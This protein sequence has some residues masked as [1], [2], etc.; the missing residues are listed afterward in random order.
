MRSIVEGCGVGRLTARL[1]CAVAVALLVGGLATEPSAFAVWEGV[2]TFGGS[3]MPVLEEMFSEETQLGGAGGMAVNVNGTGGVAPGTVYVAAEPGK[4]ARVARYSPVAGGGLSFGE[5]WQVTMVEGAYERCGPEG[6]PAYPSCA[7]VAHGRAGTVGIAVD[8]ATGNVYVEHVGSAEGEG[9]GD[10][11]VEFSPDGSKVIARF[12]K[13]AVEH[14][15][16]FETV[17]ESPEKIHEVHGDSLAVDDAGEVYV[18]D[19]TSLREERSRLMVFKPASPGDYAHYLYAGEVASFSGP[20]TPP[21]QPVIDAAGHI[22]TDD[23]DV[24]EERGVEVPSAYPA[25]SSPPLCSFDFTKG[26]ITAMT[27]DPANGEVFFFSSKSPKRVRRLGPCDRSTGKFAEASGEPEAFA[28][29]PERADLFAMA[30]D[31]SR[32]VEPLRPTGELYGVAP[33]PVPTIG[34]GE[35]GQSGLGYVFAQAQEL[36]P[37]VE[38]ESVSH[39]TAQSALLGAK[40]DSNNFETHY[41]FQYLTRSAYEA[42]PAGERFAGAVQAP[43]GGGA[44]GSGEGVS[45]VSVGLSGLAPDTEYLYRVVVSSNCSFGEP[46]KVCEATGEAQAFRT[47]SPEST[48]L[49]DDRAYELV[50]PASKLGEVLPANPAISSCANQECK[51][52]STFPHFPMQS[53]PDGEAVVYEGTDFTSGGGVPL[54][55]EY[56]SRR[57]PQVGWT[58]TNPTP[59]LLESKVGNGYLAFD[60]DLTRGLLEQVTPALNAGAPV[61]EAG[62]GFEDLYTQPTGTPSTLSSL[63]DETPPDRS[64]SGAGKFSVRFVAASA[65]LSRVF[66]EAND[67]LTGETPLAPAA[68]D[69]GS[70]EYDLYEWSAAEGLRLVNVDPGNASTEPGAAFGGGFKTSAVISND[71]SRVFWSSASGQVY[72]R[73]DGERTVRVEDPGRFLS[74]S[75]DGSRVLLNDGCLYVLTEERCEDLTRDEGGA[76]RGGFVGIVG[77]SDDL[78]HVYFI[79]KQALTAANAEGNSPN[80]HGGEEDNLYLWEQ[81]D[82]TRFVAKLLESD[83]TLLTSDWSQSPTART[84]EASPDG[85]WLAFA[86]EARLT[87]YDNVGPCFDDLGAIEYVPCSEI[88]VYDSAASRLV[89]AS[90][91]RT[92]AA[93]IGHNTLPRIATGALVTQSRYLTDAGRLLFDSQNSLVPADTNNGVEDVYEREPDG[94]GSCARVEG[95]VFLISA[96]TGGTD[97]NFLTMDETGKN[98]FFTTRDRLV[99]ADEDELIDLYDAREGGGFPSMASPS[100]GCGSEQCQPSA[101]SGGEP[102]P[103]S[104]SYGGAGNLAPPSP[105]VSSSSGSGEVMK[106]KA[107]TR[108]QKLTKALKACRVK[109]AV[110]KRKACERS[111]QKRFGVKKAA[112]RAKRTVHGVHMPTK[113]TTTAMRRGR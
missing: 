15:P 26:G 47:Y 32:Q 66:F 79:D 56:V 29:H 83:E 39:V 55:N 103:S 89:C 101:G 107:L 36:A 71:G 97:S 44:I 35:P 57:N 86:S 40:V 65:D 17:P 75:S 2:G 113:T 9:G 25:V 81:G 31:P 72:V 70:G 13:E 111:A 58:T 95:C 60:T 82:G 99:K 105:F 52:G 50:S 78:S 112:V 69:G 108:A 10:A 51:P 11:I 64:V 24:I 109:R 22:Y 30:F 14:A 63:L 49:P 91:D 5:A 1:A 88:F 38:A 42:N 27:V 61:N 74:A 73:V 106:A 102:S 16:V 37:V 98:V 77:Q 48:A 34:K 59:S 12:G 93:P 67:A 110:A 19:T 7:P 23:E 46:S 8:Q 6:E 85:H 54:E 68:V 18:Y 96:G 62:E 45:S 21:T 92:G 43:V 41:A 84:A 4:G 20:G 94:V 53:S 33:E 87:G 104:L 100:A 76:S 28:V 90:C 80:P 3:A